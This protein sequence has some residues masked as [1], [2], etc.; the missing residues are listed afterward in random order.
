VALVIQTFFNPIL[1]WL[2][3]PF[4]S[5]RCNAISFRSGKINGTKCPYWL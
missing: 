3:L 4:R 2:H 5:N 1:R